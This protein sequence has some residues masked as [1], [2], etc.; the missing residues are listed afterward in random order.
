MKAQK[1]YVH[2]SLEVNLGL[3]IVTRIPSRRAEVSPSQFQ[4][5]SHYFLPHLIILTFSGNLNRGE[6]IQSG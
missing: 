1:I 5:L 2:R 3:T 6:K 4:L